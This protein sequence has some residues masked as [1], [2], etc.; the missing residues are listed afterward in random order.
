MDEVNSARLLAEASGRMLHYTPDKLLSDQQIGDALGLSP[1]DY[2][3]TSEVDLNEPGDD[4][5]ARGVG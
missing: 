1:G 2:A 3:N 5:S 4:I